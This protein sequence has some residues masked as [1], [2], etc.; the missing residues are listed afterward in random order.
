M[1]ATCVIG[2]ETLRFEAKALAAQ[3]AMMSE[4]EAAERRAQAAVADA[5][6]E[7]EARLQ[8]AKRRLGAAEAEEWRA[9]AA[10]R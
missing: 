5:Q 10:R 7:S 4:V 1:T 6:R 9:E 8:E 2:H 3:A